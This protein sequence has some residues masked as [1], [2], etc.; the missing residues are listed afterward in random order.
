MDFDAFIELVK[1]QQGIDLSEVLTTADQIKRP[2]KALEDQAIIDFN[3]RNPMAGGGM[4]VQPSADGS[5][6][7]YKSKRVYDSPDVDAFSDALLNAYAKDDITKIVESGKSTK[8]SNVITAI[9][10]GKDKS[11]KL[12][13]VIKN[14]GL[15]EETIF[16][17]LDDRKAYID[18]AR[19][20]GPAGA[21]PRAGNFY[22]KAENWII[23]N[24]KRYADPDK[25]KKAFIRTFGTNNDLIK[26]MKKLNVPG[27]RKQTSVPFSEWFKESILGT[28]KG[29]G[30][31]Y[32]YNQLDNIFKTAIYT[33]NPNVRKNITKEIER[34]LSIPGGKG[35][36]FDI[37]N[38]I[39]NSSLFRKFGFDKQIRGPIARLLANEI[40][41]ELL[42]QVSSFRDPYLGTTE[43]IRFLKNNV[44]PKYKSMFEEA[45][46]A[47]DL[48]AKN[49]W[50]EAKQILKIK[51]NIMFDH[52]IPKELVKLGY[53]DELEYIKLNPT[54]AK[55]NTR[56]KN[57]QFDQKII[58]LAKDFSNAKTIDAKANIVTKM[59]KL[60]NDF[61]KK[62]GGYLD[63]VS[64][65]VDKTGKPIFKSSAA[66]VTKKTDFVSSLGKSMTQAGE[67]NN[68]QLETLLASFGDG[69]C[70]VQFGPKKRNGGRIG[71][72]TG[73]PGLNQ[74]IESG[75]KNIKDGKLKTA[76]QVK[77]ATKLLKAGRTIASIGNGLIKYGVIPELAFV[78]VEAAG[79]TI[80]GEKPFNAFLKSIDTLTSILPPL[81]TDFTSGIEAEKFGKFG[82]LKL[83]VDKF[84]E[85]QAKVNSLQSKLKN[86][87]GISDQGGEGYVGDLT[88]D[89][90]MIQAQLQAAEQELQKNTVSSDKVQF[91]DRKAEEIADAQMAKSAFAKQSLKDQMDGIPTVADYTETEPGRMFPK[92]PSQ[93]ELNLDLLPTMPTDFFQE[94]TS[95]LLQRSQD[96]RDQGYDI[97]TKD[98]MEYQDKLKS[99]PLSE[100]ATM[101]NPEQVYGASG[102]F[103][104]PL[105]KGGRAGFKI[106]STRKGILKL[107]DEGVKS[108]PKDITP[109]LDALIKKTLDEDFFDKKDRIVDTL[110]FK[111]AKE[112][113]N[114]PYNQ[115]VQEEPDQLEFYDDITKSNFRTKTGP[116]FDRRKRAG[117]G[118]LKQAGDSSGPPPESGPMSEGLQGLMK[119]GIKT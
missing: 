23:K 5:R 115:K 10:S 71:Y 112:R 56:I 47:A 80:L 109:D 55:F 30:A 116:F 85:S 95:D 53:A 98:L 2:E 65:N 119:R 96:L 40:G 52:K 20:G 107:I 82:D 102:T 4:L 94:K 105:A 91:I 67:I 27:A 88:S 73:T 38:E 15:D 113:K 42:D 100:L 7:G 21:N 41:Q 75:V 39:K 8:F 6:P 69:K 111:A 78:G 44:D 45:A 62:Y 1:E 48:A 28:Q 93:T 37:R 26:T 59:N 50:P 31:G 86:L 87:E 18:L 51:D 46:K 79:R 58:K 16:N 60:K 9:E 90:Q 29:S 118:I 32:N 3:K 63:D 92:Q 11:A 106:G 72:Q 89:I 14:T 57:P 33:N 97:S 22:K 24:S 83:D 103:G 54:S 77:D 76:D 81:A 34:I 84:R 35:G 64:I 99:M 49:K 104:E 66:P 101:Y 17:L 114:F 25:F 70:A 13:K 43:L 108:T 68:K 19:E 36:K 74:C 12:A 117:G 110:N 61:S